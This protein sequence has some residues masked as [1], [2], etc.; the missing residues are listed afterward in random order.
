MTGDYVRKTLLENGIV[1]ADLANK[2]GITAQSLNSRFK[3]RYFR[4]E[5][6]DEISKITGVDFDEPKSDSSLLDIIASQQRTIESLSRTIEKL[7]L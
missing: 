1:L 3:A 5:Y 4:P 7:T 2:L 6:L